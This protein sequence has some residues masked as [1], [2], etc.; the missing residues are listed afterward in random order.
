MF[1]VSY[2][3]HKLTF[4]HANSSGCVRVFG[5]S[6]FSERLHWVVCGVALLVVSIV[7]KTEVELVIASE[8]TCTS[9]EIHV[10]LTNSV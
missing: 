4:S 9:L 7:V 6:N 3:I 1:F 2:C 8:A 5:L 10:H